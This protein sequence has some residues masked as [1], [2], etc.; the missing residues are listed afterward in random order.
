MRLRD[1]IYLSWTTIVPLLAMIVLVL[2]AGMEVRGA[3]VVIVSLLLA[4]TATTSSQ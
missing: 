3:G 1:S 4:G 2:A